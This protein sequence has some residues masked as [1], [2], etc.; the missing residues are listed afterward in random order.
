[1]GH[2]DWGFLGVLLSVGLSESLGDAE[3]YFVCEAR[4]LFPHM[5]HFVPLCL[6]IAPR[7]SLV[8]SFYGS[9]LPALLFVSVIL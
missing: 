2:L 4:T 8:R 9:L 7:L 3:H 6:F 1:M 5:H